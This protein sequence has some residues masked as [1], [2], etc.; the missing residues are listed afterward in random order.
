MYRGQEVATKM[1]YCEGD[2][3]RTFIPCVTAFLPLAMMPSHNWMILG[4]PIICLEWYRSYD[5]S[6]KKKKMLGMMASE[7][8][9]QYQIK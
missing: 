7:S 9:Q 3:C 1:S 4:M 5:S 8:L 6:T 2:W